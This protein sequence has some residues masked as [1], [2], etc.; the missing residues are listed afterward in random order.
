MCARC[1]GEHAA[2]LPCDERDLARHAHGRHTSSVTVTTRAIDAVPPARAAQ[3]RLRPT[4]NSFG[5]K[6]RLLLTIPPYALLY[7]LAHVMALG[8]AMFL[9]T[10]GAPTFFFSVWW[11]I[12]VWESPRRR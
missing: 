3:R 11:T 2:R 1:N 7:F 10:V 9:L 12:R 8:T 6:G 4:V 5:W